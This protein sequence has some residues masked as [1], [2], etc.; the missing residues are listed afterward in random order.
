MER[1]TSSLKGLVCYRLL[2]MEQP[3]VDSSKVAPAPR[4]IGRMLRII[5]GAALLYFFVELIRQA[6]H[7]VAARSGW[8]V[9]RG[10]WWVGAIVCLVALPSIVNSGFGRRWD[11]WPQMVYVLL[12]CGAAVWDLLTYG[13]LWAPPLG[14]LV[15]LLFLYVFGHAGLSFLIAGIAATPG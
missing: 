9:P 11:A 13:S 14:S 4:V 10:S 5:V 3:A 6:P 12:L 7:I 15:L 1:T 2:S 8:S